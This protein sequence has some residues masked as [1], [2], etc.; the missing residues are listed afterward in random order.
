MA[1]SAMKQKAPGTAGA[2]VCWRIMQ[3]RSVPGCNWGA[4]AAKFVA[5][6]ASD[7]AD[8]R[9]GVGGDRADEGVSRHERAAV[10][11]SE[12]IIVFDAGGP[13]RGE[14][15]LE[16]H[17]DGTAPPGPRSLQEADAGCGVE[18]VE[19]L[20]YD[21]RAALHIKQGCVPGITD[22]TCEEAQAVDLGSPSVCGQE[23]RIYEHTLGPKIGPV[24]LS[25]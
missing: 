9:P 22:L 19:A 5:D 23:R 4:V 20:V 16:T 25:F 15:V 24:A 18:D 7:Q 3:I 14:T 2:S 10:A 1:Q 21:G 8:I 12:E 17:T 13:V 11:L 6:A